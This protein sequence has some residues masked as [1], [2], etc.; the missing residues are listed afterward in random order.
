MCVGEGG[1]A[2]DM[3]T[4]S[5]CCT[6]TRRYVNKDHWVES[7]YSMSYKCFRGIVLNCFSKWRPPYYAFR[8]TSWHQFI[9]Q[10]KPE[11]FKVFVLDFFC[12]DDYSC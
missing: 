11:F 2:K 7:G 5:I 6:E 3:H 8:T 1:S 12:R 10:V 9:F 4:F